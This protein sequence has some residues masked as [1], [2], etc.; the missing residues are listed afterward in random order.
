MK[1]EGFDFTV[2]PLDENKPCNDPLDLWSGNSALPNLIFDDFE[3]INKKLDYKFKKIHSSYGEC[4]SL[5]NS[6]GVVAKTFYIP[7]NDFFNKFVKNIDTLF[8]LMPK[9]F[10][11]QQSIVLQKVK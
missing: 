3:K 7:L 6:G 5:I 2:G 10:A 4:L 9:F 11:L 1:L 8:V